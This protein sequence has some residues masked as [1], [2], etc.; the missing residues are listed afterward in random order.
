MLLT[1]CAACLRGISHRSLRSRFHSSR[2]C[3]SCP[4]FSS[5]WRMRMRST[6]WCSRLAERSNCTSIADRRRLRPAHSLSSVH[7]AVHSLPHSIHAAPPALLLRPSRRL[8]CIPFLTHKWR[9]HRAG[10]S[11][12]C[13][14]PIGCGLRFSPS[15]SPAPPAWICF[16]IFVKVQSF[17]HVQEVGH[18]LFFIS[19]FSA[20]DSPCRRSK[21]QHPHA[22]PHHRL[23]RFIDNPVT[24]FLFFS[25]CCVFVFNFY[26]SWLSAQRG[27]TRTAPKKGLRGSAA[28]RSQ[29]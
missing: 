23:L 19:S 1:G 24:L 25:V 8:F 18:S 14:F 20:P 16:V 6:L 17:V 5:A 21:Q 7:I 3:C 2:C 12:C 29:W 27:W 4:L 13:R 11:C 22:V 26:L 28:A 9:V 10:H 15:P